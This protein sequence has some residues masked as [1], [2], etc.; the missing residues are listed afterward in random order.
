MKKKIVIM[1]FTLTLVASTFCVHTYTVVDGKTIRPIITL[2]Q[3]NPEE[4]IEKS[5]IKLGE[6]DEVVEKGTTFSPIKMIKIIRAKPVNLVIDG[7]SILIETTKNTVRE[8]LE[9]A[10]IAVNK[11]DKIYPPLNSKIY[12]NMKITL[13]TC[14][15]E[16]KVVKIP[17]PYKTIYEKNKM[18]EKGKVINF[19]KGS[20]GVLEKRF[21]VTYYG[22]EKISQKEISEKVVTPATSS[23]YMV[24]EAT[25][26]GRYVRKITV[27]STAYSP[28]VIETDANPWRTATGMRSGFGIVAVDPKVIP[29]GSLLYVQGYGYAVAGDTGGLIKGNRIDVFFYSTSDAYKWGRRKVTVYILPG[30]WDFSESLKY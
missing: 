9:S 14:K 6:K 26:N 20:D 22:G 30:K 13:S 7:K 21:L 24:G 19:R 18:L 11:K 27:E 10:G 3:M 25:F 1:I 8:A 16:I 4:I 5:G 12:P 15:T 23:V 28:R 17:I 29:L 2:K